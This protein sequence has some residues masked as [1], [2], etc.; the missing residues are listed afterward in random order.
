MC[1]RRPAPGWG[2]RRSGP[3]TLPGLRTSR[4]FCSGL[5]PRASRFLR[6]RP[7]LRPVA[8]PP[9]SLSGLPGPIFYQRQ[10]LSLRPA[11]APSSSPPS[12]VFP[13]F[14]RN[15]MAKRFTGTRMNAKGKGRWRK[16]LTDEQNGMFSADIPI[17]ISTSND[18]WYQEHRFSP[19]LHFTTITKEI[20]E[21]SWKIANL[22]AR[23]D[24]FKPYW[25]ML[26][27]WCERNW[28]YWWCRTNVVKWVR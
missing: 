24:G 7:P 22:D 4:F 3:S 1:R 12:A 11:I 13:V 18:R 17:E 14:G 10:H 25:C 9:F 5:P 16:F 2:L 8:T 28:G 23:G 6:G 19:D 15:P 21:N 26:L 20:L 27:V